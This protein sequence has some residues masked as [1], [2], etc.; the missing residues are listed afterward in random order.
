M[1]REHSPMT[2]DL[3]RKMADTVSKH[4]NCQWIDGHGREKEFTCDAATIEGSSYCCEHHRRVYTAYVP[5]WLKIR[6]LA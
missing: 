6:R 5:D 4:R 3:G 1:A 2:R